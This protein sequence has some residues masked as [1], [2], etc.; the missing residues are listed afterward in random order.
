[1]AKI[2][3][4]QGFMSGLPARILKDSSVTPSGIRDVGLFSSHYHDGGS[5][6]YLTIFKGSK[7]TIAAFKTNYGSL[8]SNDSLLNF[9]HDRYWGPLELANSI[10]NNPITISTIYKPS[11]KTGTAAWFC[12]Y[13]GFNNSA[14]VRGH[15][16]LGDVGLIGSGA[17]LELQDLNMVAGSL[18][19]VDNFK[20][21][22][23]SSWEY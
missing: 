11:N 21:N 3:F 23:N 18:Y 20:I 9:I 19:R 13:H 7:P 5:R 14:N 17:D 15:A 1:M 8:F 16:I 6:P 10:A 4:S 2:E 12:F 22:F